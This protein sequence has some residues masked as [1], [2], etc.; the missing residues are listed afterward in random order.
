[1]T[2]QE[3][4]DELMRVLKQFP[5]QG[6]PMVAEVRIHSLDM[7][8]YQTE[9]RILCPREAPSYSPYVDPRFTAEIVIRQDDRVIPGF[10]EIYDGRGKMIQTINMRKP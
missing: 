4:F 3:D 2:G 5:K 7:D 8:D 10:V 1:M 6:K 9:L